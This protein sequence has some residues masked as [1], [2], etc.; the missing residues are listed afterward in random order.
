MNNK[1][2]T[3]T[4]TPTRWIGQRINGL[5]IMVG[6]HEPSRTLTHL[7]I[8]DPNAAFTVGSIIKAKIIGYNKAM[9]GFDARC[10][11]ATCGGN[12]TF[13][14]K[15]PHTLYHGGDTVTVQVSAMPDEA[16][17]LPLVTTDIRLM[18]Y[19]VIL[20]TNESGKVHFSSKLLPEQRQAIEAVLPDNLPHEII[21]RSNAILYTI[22]NEIRLLQNNANN[23]DK[24]KTSQ[25]IET[26][27]DN[28]TAETPITIGQ[29]FMGGAFQAWAANDTL[30]TPTITHDNEAFEAADIF[31]LLEPL[32]KDTV[33]VTNDCSVTFENG[34]TLT[35]IDV[36][37]SG[38]AAK[39]RINCTVAA[40]LARQIPLRRLSGMIV[41]DF[42]RMK[43]KTEET[44][45]TN[46]F[47][48]IFPKDSS[49]K[50]FGFSRMGL[51]EMTIRHRYSSNKLL[52][53]QI[54]DK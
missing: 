13:L 5:D 42:L 29:D 34:K 25:I 10:D 27:L 43:N 16:D 24:Y 2:N 8:D 19:S 9:G 28:Y 39:D 17:K 11:M 52:L 32:A 14:L 30:P 46:H 49:T 50:H 26:L 7:A 31:S 20:L 45:L 36:N 47:K 40:F 1:H 54:F 23:L 12:T 33:A 35:A 41:I 53:S 48:S 37:Y 15:A 38:N 51:Y 44:A 21:V 6:I 4:T 22:N 3:I 18:G